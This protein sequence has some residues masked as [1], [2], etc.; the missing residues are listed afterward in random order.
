MDIKK[1][2]VI[3]IVTIIIIISLVCFIMLKRKQ[4]KSLRE[5]LE[6]LERQRNLIV[7]T[8]VMTELDKVKVIINNSELE[9]KYKDWKKRYELIKNER[10]SDIT[11]KLLEVD[12]L[13]E[14]KDYKDA[15]SSIIN[16]ETRIIHISEHDIRYY[17]M[18]YVKLL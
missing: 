12:N 10:Y 13:I 2:Y 14:E 16:I 15:H 4:F 18:K 11:D 3:G 17:L 9:N 7:A 5:K 1:L 8:P 6:E